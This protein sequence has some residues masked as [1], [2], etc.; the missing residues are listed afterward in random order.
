M[1]QYEGS[2]P[3][4]I[5]GLQTCSRTSLLGILVSLKYCPSTLHYDQS[6]LL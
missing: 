3:R 2:M 4:L 6:V 5:H 1:L